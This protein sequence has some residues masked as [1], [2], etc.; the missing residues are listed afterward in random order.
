MN[1]LAS[2]AGDQGNARSFV[3][4][5]GVT[6]AQSKEILEND[7]VRL[8]VDSRNFVSLINQRNGRKLHFASSAWLGLSPCLL[9]RRATVNYTSTAT[10]NV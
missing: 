4:R 8:D 3:E 5:S 7:F 10:L 9:G 1:G 2:Q 6:A